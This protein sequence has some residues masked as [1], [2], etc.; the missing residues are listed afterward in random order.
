MG[1]MFVMPISVLQMLCRAVNVFHGAVARERSV[2]V[3]NHLLLQLFVGGR[4]P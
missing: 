4:R 1:D 2:A 3:L